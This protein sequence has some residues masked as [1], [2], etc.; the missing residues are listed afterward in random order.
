MTEIKLLNELLNS[1]YHNNSNDINAVIF[2]VETNEILD[3][4]PSFL[5]VKYLNTLGPIITSIK[6]KFD[7]NGLYDN[8]V[9]KILESVE[10][11]RNGLCLDEADYLII[12]HKDKCVAKLKNLIN[13]NSK[14]TICIDINEL[15]VMMNKIRYNQEI[16]SCVVGT[17]IR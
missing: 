2:Y 16:L 5:N 14:R 8:I 7:V 15:L 12:L 11:M 10:Q 4:P 6:K 17:T 9:L 1:N 3:K 13:I